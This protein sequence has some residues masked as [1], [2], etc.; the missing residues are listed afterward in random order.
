MNTLIEAN[1]LTCL[2]YEV[3]IGVVYMKV[4]PLFQLV[5]S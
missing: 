5:L 2:K 4:V 3:D 1:L